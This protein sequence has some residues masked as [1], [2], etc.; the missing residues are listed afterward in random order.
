[1]GKSKLSV[2][3][4]WDAVAPPEAADVHRSRVRARVRWGLA[5]VVL[6][7]LVPAAF[8][9]WRWYQWTR[10]DDYQ[11]E[12]IYAQVPAL[13]DE[14]EAMDSVDRW[15]AVAAIAD[16]PRQARARAL[17]IKE[18]YHRLR[19]LGRLSAALS[20]AFDVPEAT[21]TRR[22]LAEAARVLEAS[23]AEIADPGRRAEAIKAIALA[24]CD[25][26][27]FDESV[28]VARRAGAAA[29]GKDGR[30]ALGPAWSRL[31][32]ELAKRGQSESAI[33]LACD[34]DD[35]SMRLK[36]LTEIATCPLAW[37]DSARE[38]ARRAL[39]SAEQE[40]DATRRRQALGEAATALA[41]VGMMEE[42]RATAM[43]IEP[44][45]AR[46]D[47]FLAM[48]ETRAIRVQPARAD[49]AAI[50]ARETAQE[51]YEPEQRWAVLVRLTRLL[52]VSRR[53]EQARAA[54]ML[55]AEAAADLPVDATRRLGTATTVA[56]L[57]AD[58]GVEVQAR[59][60]AYAAEEAARRV[61][62]PGA[63]SAALGAA[64]RVMARAGDPARAHRMAILARDTAMQIEDPRIR[65]AAL[66]TLCL[67]IAPGGFTLGLI[68]EFSLQIVD[69]ENRYEAVQAFLVA[70]IDAKNWDEAG[71][72]AVQARDAAARIGNPDTRSKDLLA[73]CRVLAQLDLPDEAAQTAKLITNPASHS[74]A[75]RVVAR[76]LARKRRFRE[77]R[78][79]AEACDQPVDRLEA[80][81][82]IIIELKKNPKS[83]PG[84]ALAELEEARG[85]REFLVTPP[86]PAR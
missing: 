27:M 75:C 68:E 44:K 72:L 59:E 11:A 17:A 22:E 62:G 9:G 43:R 46:C 8:A 23:V 30:T 4:D 67:T 26:G 28:A 19:A 73:V 53:M 3:L 66:R 35:P 74:A 85:G 58:A 25:A 38:A 7:L 56:S 16:D 18:P 10:T 64:A 79:T 24:L 60:A 39:A 81:T 2:D 61:S 80:F 52:I 32:V 78:E 47:V 48:L 69:P 76:F 15:L 36:A 63:R 57:L 50:W 21:V 5:L 41:A 29:G 70:A 1:M 77:A 20:R 54:A 31:A 65:D 45:R 40:T 55:V 51:L 83:T 71:L 14:L 49:E 84:S 86:Q 6:P 12:R 34:V 13:L 82:T 42:A 33:A 37:G